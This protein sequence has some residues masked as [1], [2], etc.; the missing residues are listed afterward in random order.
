MIEATNGSL[1]TGVTTNPER[2]LAEHQKK[3]EGAKFFN[4]AGVKEMVF[5]HQCLNQSE[6]LKLEYRIKQL[7]RA[8][9]WRLVKDRSRV[10][11]LMAP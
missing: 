7:K 11:Q 8:E 10:S 6:A 4:T 2:R 9:K 3:G 1:Y 5:C